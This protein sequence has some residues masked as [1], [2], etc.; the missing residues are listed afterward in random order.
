MNKNNNIF[1]NRDISWL[2]FNQRVLQEADDPS[3]PLY[4]RIKFLAIYSSNFDE[5]FR[6]RVASIRNLIRLKKKTK[7]E[8]EFPPEALLKNILTIVDKQQSF[9]NRYLFSA[10]APLSGESFH[11]SS[12]DGFD[13]NVAHTFLRELKKQHTGKTVIV[14]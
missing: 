10:V 4:E 14:V 7:E 1:F 5:F 2:S 8:L 3:V 12:I 11:I 6:V 13:S 9:D